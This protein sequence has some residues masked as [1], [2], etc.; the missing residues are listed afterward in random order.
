MVDIFDSTRRLLKSC[1]RTSGTFSMVVLSG[2]EIGEI[3]RKLE[4]LVSILHD[5]AR[6]IDILT[7]KLGRSEQ[8]KNDLIINMEKLKSELDQELQ[9]R[10]DE[11]RK[12]KELQRAL[13]RERDI[14]ENITKENE[15]TKEETLDIRKK[16]RTYEIIN[17]DLMIN[18]EKIKREM[19]QERGKR[20]Q[21]EKFAIVGLQYYERLAG[22]QYYEREMVRTRR[23]IDYGAKRIAFLKR[24]LDYCLN[25]L[26]DVKRENDRL[27]EELF[28]Y[29]NNYWDR[30]INYYRMMLQLQN[31]ERFLEKFLERNEVEFIIIRHVRE[32][33][34]ETNYLLSEDAHCPKNHPYYIQYQETN[35][36]N[37]PQEVFGHERHHRW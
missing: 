10:K 8:E 26:V 32:K 24:K 36:A 15:K 34:S 27:K 21:D 33:L 37:T 22:L 6:T 3:R 28:K 2:K 30:N 23:L 31:L 35:C 1:G 9:K 7:K 16:I 13:K 11:E 19:E 18:I 20:K 4:E 12:V 14:I 17:Y 25:E 29:K 5:D